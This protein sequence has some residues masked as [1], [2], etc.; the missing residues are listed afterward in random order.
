MNKNTFFWNNPS[1][2]IL[3]LLSFEILKFSNEES[4]IIKFQSLAQNL[5]KFRK[6]D[7]MFKVMLV[8]LK[9]YF[10]KNLN[11]KIEDIYLFMIKIIA[12]L[13]K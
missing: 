5:L 6:I 2:E 11:N 1:W 7:D 8:L 9:K 13:I 3:S 12:F 4:I 10:P